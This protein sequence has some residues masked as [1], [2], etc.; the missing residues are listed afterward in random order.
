MSMYTTNITLQSAASATGNGTA[1]SVEDLCTVGIQVKGSSF[2]GTITFEATVDDSNWVSLQ[3]ANVADGSVGT[4][5][6]SDGVFVASVAGLSQVRARVSAYT[7]GNVTVA[8][9][10]TQLGGGASLADIDI[11]GTETV[12]IQSNTAKDGSGTDYSPLLDSDGHLQMYVLSIATGTNNIGDVDI[13]SA[14]PAGTNSIGGAKDDGPQW[15]SSFGVSG[16]RFTSADATGAAADV[17]DAPTGSQKLVIT[18]IIVATDTDM[19]VDF[20]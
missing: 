17:T 2:V 11:A 15:T 16:A 14:L 8:A 3:V 7:S 4:T 13:A 6:T 20:K 5:T 9:F 10:G 18:D 12:G 1:F 19:R